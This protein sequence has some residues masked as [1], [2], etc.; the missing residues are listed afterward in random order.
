MLK[1]HNLFNFDYFH[2]KKICF[3]IPLCY[4]IT[5]SHFN[6]FPLM[7]VVGS[8]GRDWSDLTLNKKANISLVCRFNP[9]GKE[10]EEESE[11]RMGEMTDSSYLTGSG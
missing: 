6:H 4:P 7:S 10:E 1:T 2:M 9:S 11:G 5:V 8:D 3:S